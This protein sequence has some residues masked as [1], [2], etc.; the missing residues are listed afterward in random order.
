[1]LHSFKHTNNEYVANSY[2]AFW[3]NPAHWATNQIRF[4]PFPH[5]AAIIWLITIYIPTNSTTAWIPH[6][7]STRVFTTTL[8]PNELSSISSN[9]K[10]NEIDYSLF[11]DFMALA[12]APIWRGIYIEQKDKDSLRLTLFTLMDLVC[13]ACLITYTFNQGATMTFKTSTLIF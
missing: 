2:I 1:M 5:L 3:R 8:F 12:V 9:A 10:L 6:K 11:F 13:T 7:Y 4:E